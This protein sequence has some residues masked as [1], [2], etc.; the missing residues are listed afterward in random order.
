MRMRTALVPSVLA[1]ILAWGAASDPQKTFDGE[2][3][4]FPA[5]YNGREVNECVDMGNGLYCPVASGQYKLCAFS[6]SPSSPNGASPSPPLEGS[7]GPLP[8]VADNSLPCTAPLMFYN[9]YIDTCLLVHSRLACWTSDTGNWSDCS[10]LS[11]QPPEDIGNI[12]VIPTQVRYLE[13]GS[14]C[15]L[16][17]VD[18]SNRIILDCIFN[19]VSE[20]CP[21]VEGTPP[22]RPA[23]RVNKIAQNLLFLSQ[24]E[25]E[26]GALCALPFVYK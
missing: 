18:R 9:Q 4:Q 5:V 13:N 21:S 7:A 3:C 11:A 8:L 1:C 24:R 22:C 26:S 14:T 19:G 16:P 12:P 15:P 20:Y 17:W 2:L 6:N 10:P 23:A 25:T